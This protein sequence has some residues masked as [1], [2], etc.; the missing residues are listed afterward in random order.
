NQ[1]FEIISDCLLFAGLY[2]DKKSDDISGIIEDAVSLRNDLIARTNNPDGKDDPKIVKK[3]YQL[4]ITDL[5]SG[6]DKL[7]SRLSALSSKKKK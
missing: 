6:A 3:H 1:L 2:P 7:C 4:V 5:N